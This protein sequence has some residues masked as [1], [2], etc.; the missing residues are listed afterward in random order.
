VH[1]WCMDRRPHCAKRSYLG[2]VELDRD[3]VLWAVLY[4]D[5]SEGRAS[6]LD[7]EVV[8]SLRHGKR[9]VTNMVLAQANA[10]D[11]LAGAVRR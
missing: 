10:A 4:A 3:G 6:M 8:R 11:V 7:R 2:Q 9:R 5:R 1:S